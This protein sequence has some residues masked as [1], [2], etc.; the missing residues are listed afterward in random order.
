MAKKLPAESTDTGKGIQSRR[1]FLG[2]LGLGAAA[3]AAVSSI[4]FLKLGQNASGK[5]SGAGPGND[6]IFQPRQDP[7]N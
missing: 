1:S 3:L 4:P 2:K 7:G 6:S 5:N